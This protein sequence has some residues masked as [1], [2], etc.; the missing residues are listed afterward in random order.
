MSSGRGSA[1]PVDHNRCEERGNGRLHRDLEAASATG[2]G[3]AR[4]RLLA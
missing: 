4:T 2:F 3:G 1:Q